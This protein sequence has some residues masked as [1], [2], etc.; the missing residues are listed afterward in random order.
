[1]QLTLWGI[2][3]RTAVVHTLTY[4][5]VGLTA[6]RLF[7][8][9]TKFTDPVSAHQR[10]SLRSC[11]LSASRCLVPAEQRLVDHVDH[12]SC[13]R[14]PLNLRARTRFNRGAHLYESILQGSVG[15]PSRSPVAV[16][17]SF[18]HHVLLGE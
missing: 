7:N 8:Y 11:L 5:A 4:F 10:G 14:H 15:R 16:I 3:A 12:L 17:S 1:M 2:V 9:S 18:D 6:F 13:D